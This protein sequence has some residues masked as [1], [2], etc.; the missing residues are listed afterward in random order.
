MTPRIATL[1]IFASILPL[2]AC[3]HD[4]GEGSATPLAD[5]GPP[6]AD[7]D[8]PEDD[9]LPPN[10]DGGAGTPMDDGI[11]D[12]GA[13]PPPPAVVSAT[14][15]P[16]KIRYVLV[17]VKEN[18]TFDNYFTDFPGASSATTG[19]LSTGDTIKRMPA[20]RGPLPDGPCHSNRCGQKAYRNGAMNGFDLTG[21][22]P[23][24]LPFVYYPEDQIP[25]YWRYARNFV[26]ADHFFSTTLG[27]STPG[28]A[29]FW[30]G[31]SMVLDNAK[32]AKEGGACSGF[33]CAAGADVLATA[34]NPDSCT[35]ARKPPCFDVPVLTDHLPGGF[36]WAN[37]GGPL[38]LMVK[39]V[40]QLPAY[41]SHFRKQADM[42]ADLEAGRVYNLMIGHL[43]SGEV[44]EHPEAHPC[45]GENFS[46]RII[47]AAMK[48]P[49]WKEMAIIL[50]WDDWGGF[51]DHVRPPVHKCANGE[52]FQSGFRLPLMVISPY[53][54]K[55]FVLTTPAEQAS[56][57][58][59]VEDLWGMK[60]MSARDPHARDGQAGSLMGAFDFTQPPRAPMLL[61][62]H[63]C[64]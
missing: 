42:A 47:N 1:T 6:P 10:A 36:T 21:T 23:A 57:P 25:N 58:R 38:P 19:K 35:T 50:T 49:Q 44:S 54:K 2:A 32:C 61:Q 52:I 24:T 63:A 41:R 60:Y 17:L 30:T 13:L 34:Y 5:A 29:V 18:H 62:E 26:L 43:W 12:G 64:P 28:H 46:V 20:P 11:G 8:E 31:Q 45:A 27:P 37:Y 39:S 53:A 51:Y 59:L 4:R 14:P 22:K 7:D 56:V 33:G 16:S 55:G 40:S 3:D 9:G 15:I 48:T